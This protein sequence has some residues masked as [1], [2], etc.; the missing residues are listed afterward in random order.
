[1][2][3]QGSLLFTALFMLT[4]AISPLE[5]HR[6]KGKPL[7][8][9]NMAAQVQRATARVL[10]AR[11]PALPPL[12]GKMAQLPDFKP[13]MAPVGFDAPIRA[14]VLPLKAD[15][16]FF[17]IEKGLTAS[18]FVIEEEFEGKKQLWG[19][20][21]AHIAH[22]LEPFPA[23]W[24]QGRLLWPV[25]FV[26]LGNDGM[27]DVALF[28]LPDDWPTPV[29]PLKLAEKEPELGEKTYSFGFFAND[30]YLVPNREIKEITP[31]RLVT[32]L[33][34]TT[35]HRGGACGGPI[36]NRR[37]EVVGLHVGSSDAKKVSFALPA[38]EIRRLLH[39][40]RNN[41][42]SLQT[43][44]FN[45]A[46]IGEIN[47]N[48]SILRV[49]I[50]TNGRIT[51]DFAALHQEKQ[52]DYA[53]LE[54]L[55]PGEQP[56]EVQIIVNHKPFSEQEENQQEFFFRLSYNFTTQTAERKVLSENVQ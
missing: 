23:L 24:Q 11:P 39:A 20:T 26:A 40:Y 46:N 42:R 19:V 55:F 30:F 9:I 18:S 50:L 49:R 47:I 16:D 12:I 41:G 13:Y 2:K 17:G 37:G 4:G 51:H 25:D 32:S 56:E 36:L 34:F 1:M 28:P 45:G 14:S 7:P 54:T 8:Q 43:L 15:A 10:A 6:F 5:A 29:T 52:I 22:L 53:H 27:A 3:T 31:N 21:A 48:E 38:H 44:T 35:I 33:E